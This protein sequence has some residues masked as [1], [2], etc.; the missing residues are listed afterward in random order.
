[1]VEQN[2]VMVVGELWTWV[3]VGDVFIV[4]GVCMGFKWC[5]GVE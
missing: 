4:L 2:G 5:C 1:M 3:T